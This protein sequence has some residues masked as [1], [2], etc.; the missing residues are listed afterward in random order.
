MRLNNGA[1]IDVG[2]VTDRRGL[3]G[4]LSRRPSGWLIGIVLSIARSRGGLLGVVLA[5]LLLFVGG[6]G[7]HAIADRGNN[8]TIKH[9]CAADNATDQLDCRNV[10]YINSI[11][12]YWSTAL[13]PVFGVKYAEA[14]TVF[15]SDRTNTG[16]GQADSGTGPFYCSVDKLVYLDLSFYKELAKQLGAPGEFAQPYVLAHEYGHHV[17]DLIGT[18]AAM[19]SAQKDRPDEP[20]SSR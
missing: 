4:L 13:P 10:L 2:Q 16:C 17:Q 14:N 1:G 20:T 9:E 7:V 8:S 3:I 6:L 15:F 18:E 12:N 5:L 11:Q 19:R